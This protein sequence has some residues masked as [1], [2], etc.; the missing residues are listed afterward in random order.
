[1]I[2]DVLSAVGNGAVYAAA[3]ALAAVG[4]VGCVLPYPG[5]PF[6]LLGCAAADWASGRFSAWWVWLGLIVLAIAGIFVDNVTT[7]LG[8]KRFGSS[9]AAIWCSILGL[10]IGGVFFPP[11]GLLLGPFLGAFF[12]ELIFIRKSLGDSAKS[13]TGALLGYLIGIAAKLFIAILM[14]AFYL[15]V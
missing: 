7:A 11:L 10:L 12:A 9:R 5:H 2:C 8:A 15:L 13:G 1:M 4:F 14:V 6:I 3:V